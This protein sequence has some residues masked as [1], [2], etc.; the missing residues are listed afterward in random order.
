[1]GGTSISGMMNSRTKR[2][3][4]EITFNMNAI[5]I[6]TDGHQRGLKCI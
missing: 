3:R 1:M 2:G 4:V 6:C 5:F